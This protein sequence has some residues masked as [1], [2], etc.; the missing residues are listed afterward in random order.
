MSQATFKLL[1][2]STQRWAD[3]GK[4]CDL[5]ILLFIGDTGCRAG[6]LCKL[7]IQ[8]V[9]LEECKAE[10]DGK[11]GKRTVHFTEPTAKAIQAWLKVRPQNE[12]SNLF[13][14]MRLEAPL[15][16]NG[17]RQILHRHALRAHIDARHNPHAIRH[18]VGQT[19][20]DNGANLVQV[21]EKLGHTDIR[22]TAMFYSHQDDQ[23]RAKAATEQFSIVSQMT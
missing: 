3:S 13:L 18:M 15:T 12:H 22:T 14:S 5:A 2:A 16:P 9:D 8:D 1:L 20:L 19:W 17:L 6:E 21:K 23:G 4:P 7:E 10:V 11:T